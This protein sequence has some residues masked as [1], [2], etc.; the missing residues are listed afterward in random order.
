VPVDFQKKITDS[1]DPSISDEERLT[2]VQQASDPVS[3]DAF[4]VPICSLTTMVLVNSDITGAETMAQADF[5][6]SVDSRYPG[7]T[8]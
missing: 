8:K 3:V 2:L 4:E 1:L 6:D 5:Q 7:K